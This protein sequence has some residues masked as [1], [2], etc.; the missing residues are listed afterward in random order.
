MTSDEVTKP[1]KSNAVEE[2][3][4]L[5]IKQIETL[6]ETKVAIEETQKVIFIKVKIIIFS[7]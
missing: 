1:E 4:K 2:I 3:E 7:H 6:S 5:N